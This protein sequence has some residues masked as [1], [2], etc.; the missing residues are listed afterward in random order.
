[1]V[2][3]SAFAVW[4]VA[5]AGASQEILRNVDVVLS[6]P[7]WDPI[8]R[9][10]ELFRSL[11]RIG[12]GGSTHVWAGP[13]WDLSHHD[14]NSMKKNAFCRIVESRVARELQCWNPEFPYV[15]Q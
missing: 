10:Q 15:C 4:R 13:H 14:S 11:T 1:M 6:E 7:G 5:A 12:M 8:S 2:A 9:V 3:L